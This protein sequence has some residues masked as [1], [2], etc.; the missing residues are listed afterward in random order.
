[1]KT[2]MTGCKPRQRSERPTLPEKNL[3]IQ[4]D[5][6]TAQKTDG[7]PRGEHRERVEQN[8][9]QDFLMDGPRRWQVVLFGK[10]ARDLCSSLI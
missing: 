8:V 7:T 10:K 3:T 2:V 1:M 6:F 9:V 4:L 5:L